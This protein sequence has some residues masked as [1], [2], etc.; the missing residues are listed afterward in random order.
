MASGIAL[1]VVLAKK[2]RGKQRDKDQ[3]S[4]GEERP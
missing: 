2:V 1:L 4:M 3:T